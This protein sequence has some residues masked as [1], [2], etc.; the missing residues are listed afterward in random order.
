MADR[1]EARAN[2]PTIGFV[3]ERAIR[4]VVADLRA[5]LTRAD[6]AST[7]GGGK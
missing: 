3:E 1:F 2:V 7:G 6:A 4:S 5:L